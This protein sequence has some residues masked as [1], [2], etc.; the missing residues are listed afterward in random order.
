MRRKEN[1]LNKHKHTYITTNNNKEKVINLKTKEKRR[2]N[3]D[4]AFLMLRSYDIHIYV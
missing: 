2:N 1:P 4:Y 3:C